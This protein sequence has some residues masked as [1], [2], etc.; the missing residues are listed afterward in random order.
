MDHDEPQAQAS[1]SL[2]RRSRGAED[3]GSEF[4]RAGLAVGAIGLGGA[5]LGAVCPLCVVATPALVGLGA[6]QK[7]R[8][9]L[10]ARQASALAGR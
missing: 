10:L 7:L 2:W 9:R 3:T 5:L 4:L 6:V 8:A 1:S